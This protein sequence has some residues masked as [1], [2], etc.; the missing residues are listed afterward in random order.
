MSTKQSKTTATKANATQA[1]QQA[2]AAQPTV[3]S[4]VVLAT[5]GLLQKKYT[6]P[7][8]DAARKTYH[9]ATWQKAALQTATGGASGDAN[10]VAKWVDSGGSVVPGPFWDSQYTHT[11]T[12]LLGKGVK[13]LDKPLSA[14]GNNT[15]ANFNA[16]IGSKVAN[17]S[18][19]YKVAM[20][21]AMCANTGANHKCNT[22]CVLHYAVNGI[23][24]NKPLTGDDAYRYI[25][26]LA[27]HLAFMSGYIKDTILKAN[28]QTTLDVDA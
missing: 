26:A 3:I 14:V 4:D 24:D 5:L 10:D 12:K 2:P 23:M 28:W 7:T 9:N 25:M 1:K 20:Y 22:H 17:N 18:Q 6:Q 13:Q 27:G 21:A 16:N 11:A 15:L 8:L 19:A